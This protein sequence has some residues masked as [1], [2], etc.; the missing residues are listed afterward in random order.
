MKIGLLTFVCAQNWGAVLQG[1]ST[2]EF[3]NHNTE[4]TC[5]VLNWEPVDNSLLKPYK[6][7]PNVVHSILNISK[8]KKRI[9][10]F[11]NFRS[12]Y[13]NWS[14]RCYTDSERTSLNNIYQ[15]FIVGSDQV[16]ITLERVNPTM[17]LDFVSS[18]NRKISYAP[19]FGAAKVNER[20]ND[21][22]KRYIERFDSVSVREASGVAIIR[23]FSDIPV[24]VVTDPVFLN[25]KE[26]W[27]KLAIAPKVKGNYVFLYPTQ[28]TKE[29]CEVVKVI[30]KRYKLPI[31]TPFYVP[32]CK[33][34][35][36]MGVLEFLGWIKDAEYV[37]AT[38]FHATAFSIIFEKEF[39]A[40]PHTSTGARII[41]MLDSFRI[42]DSLVYSIEDIN[43]EKKINYNIVSKNVNKL[44]NLSKQWL[45][46]ALDKTNLQ[47]E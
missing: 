41:D 22:L 23:K 44:A 10:K 5:E 31:Y 29:F 4:H 20:C 8:C 36:D 43:Y 46:E 16:W 6:T 1:Y 25:D 3:I 13:L 39:W 40:M 47:G 2:Q 11:Q 17:F 34:I 15:A 24:Q 28:I 26:Y 37:F 45:I 18:E 12:E 27:A 21:E 32:G 9:E 14:P 42:K 30:K 19:S 38:S 35:K 7:I 33:T